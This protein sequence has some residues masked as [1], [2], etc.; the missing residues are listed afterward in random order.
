MGGGPRNLEACS[1]KRSTPSAK[2]GCSSCGRADRADPEERGMTSQ[3]TWNADWAQHTQQLRPSSSDE[4]RGKVPVFVFGR[5]TAIDQIVFL[6][7]K[8]ESEAA[9]LVNSYTDS[10]LDSALFDRQPSTINLGADDRRPIERQ[11]Q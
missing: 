9:L 6:E 10:L 4:I 1:Q 8:L 7:I 11:V 3:F 2:A 5:K